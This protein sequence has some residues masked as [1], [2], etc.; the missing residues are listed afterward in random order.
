MIV[1][2]DVEIKE[3]IFHL[4]KNQ[5][6]ILFLVGSSQ[7]LLGTVTDGDVRR[8]FVKGVSPED[9]ISAI[10]SSNPIHVQEDIGEREV[11]SLLGDNYKIGHAR[12]IPVVDDQHRILGFYSLF[13]LNFIPIAKP[14]LQKQEL[15]YLVDCV[16]ETWISSKGKYIT[17]FENAFSAFSEAKYGLAVSNGT[18]ALHLA[19]E[20]LGIGPGD[21]VI[22]PSLTFIATANAVSYTGAKPVF[23][24]SETETWN[25]SPAAIEELITPQTKAIIPVHLY[26]QPCKMA[27][28]MA[29][30]DQH[31][32]YV[33]EDA[34]E[35]HGAECK[36]K[37]VGS[38]GHVGCFSFFGNKIIT[39]GEGGMIVTNNREWYEKAKMLRDHGMDPERKYWHPC[40]GY[41][42]RMTNMQAAIGLAQTERID[43]ILERKFAVAGK[44]RERLAGN[45]NLILPPDNDWSVNVYWMFSIVFRESNGP[46]LPREALMDTAESQRI[47]T[48]PF[49][50]PVHTMPPYATGQEL[51]VSE[52][53]AKN[54]L[55]LPSYFDISDEEIER[56]CDI[57][58]EH[59]K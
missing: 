19:L 45:K 21:E 29:I 34:A 47:E 32:L 7:E 48:R 11:L 4:N 22:V 51:S 1:A 17:E 25:I 26:G 20:V 13:D 18:A 6:S 49:F 2:A 53:L 43:Q 33:I 59:M 41:N 42:Y 56:I 35:A 54:G 36:G 46:S 55:C 5:R 15:E 57:I 10:M 14:D 24:D 37:K 30:A 44:Y 16:E 38:I 58:N 31:S 40:V 50:Y 27:E 39:T 52:F 23:A 3:A 28:I 12:N 9:K 8:A